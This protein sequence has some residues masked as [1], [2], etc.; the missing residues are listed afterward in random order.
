[1]LSPDSVQ[2]NAPGTQ[3]YNLY[4]YVANNPTTW[5]DPTGHSSALPSYQEFLD[6]TGTGGLVGVYGYIAYV[7]KCVSSGACIEPSGAAG[8]RAAFGSAS[9]Y[10]AW[11]GSPQETVDA[12]TDH[13]R[14]PRPESP[15]VDHPY[16]PDPEQEPREDK[17]LLRDKLDL[18]PDC[19]LAAMGTFT[20]YAATVSFQAIAIITSVST[21]NPVAGISTGGASWA[22]FTGL[23]AGI[24]A[25]LMRRA[26]ED[27]DRVGHVLNTI[28]GITLPYPWLNV[29]GSLPSTFYSCGRDGYSIIQR[30]LD[31]R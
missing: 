9:A 25:E 24:Q 19:V 15:Q 22:F 10:G 20:S 30:Y 21:R 8:V 26:K 13:P 4:A 11:V 29:A 28:A 27:G 2:P 12:V 7:L 31:P 17:N 14:S 16:P 23:S 3:G 18:I 6:A 5:V 1:M